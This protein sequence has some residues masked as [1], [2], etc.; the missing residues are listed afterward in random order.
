MR[1]RIALLFLFS[2]GLAMISVTIASAGGARSQ[3]LANG[4]GSRVVNL[5][6]GAKSNR[7]A[8]RCPIPAEFRPAFECA[9]RQTGVAISFLTAVA[10]VESGFRPDAVSPSGARGLLQVLPS[11]ARDLGIELGEPSADVLAGAE[12]LHEML[13]RFST[14]EEALAAYNAGPAA[15]SAAGGIPSSETRAYVNDVLRRWHR[16]TGCS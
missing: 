16:L 4:A 2:L 11:T 13:A 15:V 3:T 9:A 14:V 5:P 12:Y 8:K 7:D 6:Q 1:R 10:E